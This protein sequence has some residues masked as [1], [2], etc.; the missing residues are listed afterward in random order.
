MRNLLGTLLAV[1][2]LVAGVSHAQLPEDYGPEPVGKRSVSFSHPLS[3]NNTVSAD[4]FYPALSAGQNAPPNIA[5]GPYP[6]VAFLHGYFAPP[7]FYSD[8]TTHI[9]SYGFVVVAVSTETGFFQ[10][11]QDLAHDSHALLH[12][13]DEQG[14]NP[15]SFL[16][17]M[18]S[19][20]PWSAVGHSNG[21]A[22]IFY[23][24]AWEDR[25]E[26]IVSTEGNWFNIPTVGQFD[27]S[28]FS[29][30]SSEDF[31]TPPNSNARRYYLEAHS[32]PRRSYALILGG[33]HNGSLDF[34]SSIHSLS[35]SEQNRL[36]RRMVTGFLRAEVQG[37]ENLYTYLI[38]AGV[39][40]EPINRETM[41][42]RPVLWVD[43]DGGQPGTLNAGMAAM[44]GDTVTLGW[45]RGN[46]MQT[47]G[48]GVAGLS[49]LVF[50][51]AQ[52]S[53]SGVNEVPTAL[54]T[55][56][57][58]ASLNVRGLRNAGTNWAYT[59]SARIQVP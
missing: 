11:I 3:G 35:H 6:L 12:W 9:A 48:Q 7:S 50:H 8:L 18:P 27:G 14:A 59:R 57:S 47:L 45:S 22:A 28:F 44:P 2:G 25:I 58:G 36:H 24:L 26:Y 37:E 5:D 53:A 21:A 52:V 19:D 23:T 42:T 20:G 17:N 56:L 33:G 54:P 31:L 49:G 55:G 4:V 29:I 34:P 38:G 13:A 39:L 43:H 46:E 1:A 10:N 51:T 16:W 41:C 40:T 30:G 32:A 15:A